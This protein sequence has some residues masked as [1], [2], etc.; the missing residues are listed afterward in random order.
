M[1]EQKVDIDPTGNYRTNI[2][3]PIGRHRLRNCSDRKTIMIRIQH[4]VI[5]RA[6][7]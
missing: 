4:F 7:C 1:M 5:D 6:I 3:K 2:N